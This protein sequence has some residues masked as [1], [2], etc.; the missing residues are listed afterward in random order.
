MSKKTG[1]LHLWKKKLPK[2]ARQNK[3]RKWSGKGGASTTHNG[4]KGG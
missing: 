2:I 3:R 4:K 1:K